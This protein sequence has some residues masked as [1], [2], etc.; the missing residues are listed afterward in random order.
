MVCYK[1]DSQN[2]ALRFEMWYLLQ[3]QTSRIRH[4]SFVD[5]D[6][7]LSLSHFDIDSP[8]YIMY[9]LV[10]FPEKFEGK[11]LCGYREGA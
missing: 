1:P 8:C 2:N 7:N 5:L 6:L 9:K 10:V 11:Y 3:T 4:H